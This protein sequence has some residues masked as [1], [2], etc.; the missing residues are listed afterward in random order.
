MSIEDLQEFNTFEGGI[1]EFWY[2]ACPLWH[3]DTLIMDERFELILDVIEFFMKEHPEVSAFCL[4]STRIRYRDV[5]AQS[6]KPVGICST[7]DS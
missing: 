1:P 7:S 3:E 2:F 6:P 5:E 4:L